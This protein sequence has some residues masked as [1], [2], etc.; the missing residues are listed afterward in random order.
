MNWRGE[1]LTLQVF[2][3]SHSETIGMTLEGI[4]AGE[5]IDRAALQRFLDRR[6]PGRTPWSTP[7]KEPDIPIFSSG[8]PEDRTDGGA[9]TARIRNTDRRSKDYSSLA[10][11]PRPG[12]AD[13][14]ASVKYG[15]AWSGAGGGAFSG[16]MT[17]PVCIAGGICLQLLEREGIRVIS[18]ISELDGI[19]DEGE[20]LKSTADKT[21]PVVN[22][23]SG[24][25]MIE[26]ILAVKAAGDSVGG[27]VEC[28]VHGLPVGLGGP[29][30]EGMESRIANLLFGIPAVK[31]VEF[32]AGFAVSRLRG[33][34]NNDP[35]CLRDGRVETSGN[36]A[37]GIL[38]GITNGMPL[39]FRAAFKPTPSIS[40]P[41]RSVD[42]ERMEE[43]EL[44]VPGRH[45]PCVVPRAVPVVEAAAALAVYDALLSR[46]KEVE[47]WN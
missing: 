10:H 3:A 9:I 40:L 44:C 36:H 43:T 23:A 41:Q 24:Q 38:G 47:A 15:A 14:P 30:F 1:Q 6:A 27:V 32:G 42:L 11:T 35:F 16:R 45:D 7:R 46:R 33:S 25:C 17:A 28:S 29:L 34:E 39:V 26:R 31:G 22:D 8:I 21:F 12:H 37:G 5:R 19:R 2:G 4:P 18:R 13:Y 20:L